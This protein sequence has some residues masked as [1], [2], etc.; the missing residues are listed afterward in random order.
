MKKLSEWRKR[1][2]FLSLKLKV[3]NYFWISRDSKGN[4][5]TY[6]KQENR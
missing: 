1:M 2:I 3:R 5:L 4:G 6:I